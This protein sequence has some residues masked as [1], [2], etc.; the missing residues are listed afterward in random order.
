MPGLRPRKLG[1][2]ACEVTHCPQNSGSRAFSWPLSWDY[3]PERSW[4][5]G[6]SGTKAWGTR[7]MMLGRCGRCYLARVDSGHPLALTGCTHPRVGS[8]PGPRSTFLPSAFSAFRVFCVQHPSFRHLPGVR[9]N[10]LSSWLLRHL[11]TGNH[12]HF[13]GVWGTACTVCL[14]RPNVREHTPVN[15]VKQ[16]RGWESARLL[17]LVS[18]CTWPSATGHGYGPVA[19]A[20]LPGESLM[21]DSLCVLFSSCPQ[22]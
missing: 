8:S 11:A 5:N 7:S 20:A 13:Q 22:R 21:N 12:S 2:R 3:V 18:L 10:L 6:T 4:E 16:E 9:A 1:H 17:L 14:C 19:C 15:E